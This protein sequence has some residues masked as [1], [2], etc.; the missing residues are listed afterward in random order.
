MGA[1]RLDISDGVTANMTN[2]AGFNGTIS[3]QGALA[4]RNSQIALQKH[5]S[6]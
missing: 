3:G 1:G 4:L 2:I 6:G 5:T